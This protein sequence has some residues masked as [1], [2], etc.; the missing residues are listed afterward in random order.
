MTELIKILLVEDSQTHAEMIRHALEKAAGRL[1]VTVAASLAEARAVLAETEPDLLLV[2]YQLPDGWGT[3][4]LPDNP[5]QIR[6]PLV[7]LT[8]Q[9]DEQVAVEAIKGGALDYVVK[10][11]NML[12]DMPHIVERSLREWGHIV[13]HRRAVEQAAGF[14]RLLDASLNEIYTFDAET[15]RFVQVNRGAL[16]NIGYSMEELRQ[17]TPVDLKQDLTLESFKSLLQPLRDGTRETIT[18]C[19]SHQRKNGSSYPVEAHLQLLTLEGRPVFVAMLLDISDR[20][21]AENALQRSEERFRSIFE[22]AAAGM[23]MIAPDGHFLQVNPAFVRFIGYQEAELLTMS[24][25]DVTHAE[26]RGWTRKYFQLLSR[27]QSRIIDTEKRYLRK[28]GTVLWGHTSVSCVLEGEKAEGY[29]VGLV[30]DITRRKLMEERLQEV[31]RELDAF[32][33]TVSHDL[34]T[35]LTPIVGYAQYLKSAYEEKLDAQALDILGE[36]DRQGQIMAA[37]IE[38]LLNLAKVGALK[39]PDEPL[40]VAQVVSDLLDVMAAQ[41]AEAGVD[42]RVESFPGVR[43]PKT[44]LSQIFDNLIGNAIRYAGSSGG[45]I[46]VGGVRDGERVRLFVRDHGPGIPE[47]E[48]GKIFEAFFRGASGKDLRGTG[49][50]LATIRKIARLYDGRAWVEDTP[51]GG[52]TFWVELVG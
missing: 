52:A 15:L 34:R 39:L 38:D 35:P 37:M 1:Q 11:A 8:G 2:D 45:P 19:S 22:T 3:E 48:K 50:G 40:D 51:E 41:I 17:L 23:V 32:V 13:E 16:E 7:F 4:L 10:T 29:C 6:W 27:E 36:I 24:V 18:F 31:N 12:E 47:E 42:I 28:D 9:G 20:K 5:A 43:L 33:Y 46:E 21:R 26:D 49:I 44:L 30:Q 14:G 25:L